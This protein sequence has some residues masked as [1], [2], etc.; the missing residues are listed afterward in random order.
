MS[1]ND[2]SEQ[3]ELLAQLV[4]L[5]SQRFPDGIP[6]QG[7]DKRKVWVHR[8]PE[9]E[10]LVIERDANTLWYLSFCWESLRV[11]LGI[12]KTTGGHQHDSHVVAILREAIE[13][14]K[15]LPAQQAAPANAGQ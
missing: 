14:V 9:G 15:D 7:L 1:Q 6:R 3:V 13:I 5:L 8:S 12:D 10:F 4:H 2:T 11:R